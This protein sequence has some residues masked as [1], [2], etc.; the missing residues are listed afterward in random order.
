MP[1]Y[2]LS[3]T[4]TYVPAN[5][6]TSVR[7]TLLSAS[8]SS[9]QITD[10]LGIQPDRT[11][12]K[13]QR[14]SRR[15]QIDHKFHG[16]QVES[17]APEGASIADHLDNLLDRLQGHVRA[18]KAIASDP[19]AVT[20]ARCWIGHHVENWNPG[21]EISS[22][23]LGKLSRMG[24]ALAVDIYVYEAGQLGPGQIPRRVPGRK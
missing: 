14:R 17:R 16:W 12:T 7:L 21:L 19:V 6:R 15:S 18:I 22:R 4:G 9:A 3:E 1:T 24:V 10:R 2:A 23:Q 20:S 5:T 11:W 8:L 13:G